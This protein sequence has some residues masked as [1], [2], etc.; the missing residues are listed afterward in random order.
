ML[1]GGELGYRLLTWISPPARRRRPAPAG[2]GAGPSK[3]ELH[4]GPGVWRELAGKTVLDFGCG[5]GAEAIDMARLGARRVIGL[6]IRP[7]VLERARRDAVRAGVH[8][9]CSFVTS[10]DVQADVITSIDAFEHFADPAAVLAT[11]ASL[12]KPDGRVLVSF[13]PPW[14]HPRGG[15]GFSVFPWA[16]LLFTERALLRWRAGYKDDGA[17]RFEEVGG[18]LNRMTVGRFRRL[19]WESPFRCAT[20]E[21]VPIRAARPLFNPLTRELF[22]SLVRCRLVR[23]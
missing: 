10:T 16:H 23:S 8:G 13:G 18:G 3:L 21:T 1:I 19:V 17:T 4:W 7:E 2:E 14:F 12:L 11:M 20:F 5:F 22:T 9:R 6:D 15:H